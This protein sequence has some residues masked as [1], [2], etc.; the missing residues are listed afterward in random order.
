MKIIRARHSCVAFFRNPLKIKIL[1][2]YCETSDD[3]LMTISDKQLWENRIE[4]FVLF[5]VDVRK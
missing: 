2:T 3:E 4:N 1:R 5:I